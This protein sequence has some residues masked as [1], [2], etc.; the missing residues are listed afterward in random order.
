MQNTFTALLLI[1]KSGMLLKE[2][3]IES[4]NRIVVYSV[5]ECQLASCRHL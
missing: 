3:E 5:E 1:V 4:R 2:S